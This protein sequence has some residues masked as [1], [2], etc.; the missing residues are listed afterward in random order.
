MIKEP[1]F[2]EPVSK[3]M[4]W[5]GNRMRE[6]FGFE[7]PGEDTGEAW[8]VSAHEQGDCRIRNGR[9][10][11]KTLGWLWKKHRELF[12]NL[13]GEVFPLLVKIIDAKTDLS[14]QVH[15][16]TAYAR[17][18]E[19]GAL[20]KT[21][22]WYILDCDADAD[23]VI[24]HNARNRAELR[25]MIEEKRFLDLIKIR[26]IKKGDFF[27][28]EP[29]TVHAI[30][31]GTM[32]LEIQQNSAIT[33]R[34]YDYDRL[35]N[36]KPR[37]LHIEKSI[38]VI[39]CPHTESVQS[40]EIESGDGYMCKRMVSGAAFTV[41][42]WRIESTAPLVQSHPFMIVNVMEG[43]GKI[44]GIPVKKGDSMIL[45]YGYGTC[46]AEGKLELFTSYV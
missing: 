6:A 24:G 40:P 37:E 22:C 7:I 38:D 25:S 27:Q 19:N 45:P 42:Q 10:Q 11:G 14:I 13:P 4:I 31:S 28:I 29:G 30:R 8:V 21:E 15:P 1:I 16:D 46:M 35:Q 39:R 26:P 18:H 43:R 17:I 5:G 33:Y 34:L 2:L 23:I 20:G 41:D 36:G 3:E 44:G 9:F 12:G 32:L